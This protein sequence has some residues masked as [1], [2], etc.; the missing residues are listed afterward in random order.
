M[1]AE[2]ER[3]ITEALL[4][5]CRG[6]DR[7]DPDALLAAFHPGAELRDYGPEPMTVEAFTEYALPALQR[8]FTATQHRISNTAIDLDDEGA[9]ALVE[10]YVL[11]F[12]A[13]GDDDTGDDGP[14]KLHTFNGRYIDRFERRDDRWLIARRTLR[15]DWTRVETIDEPMTGAWIASGRAGSSD[16][17]SDPELQ[18]DR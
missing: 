10:T 16:P 2:V 5:Y 11:A 14:A 8:R 3:E 6:I 15:V 13:T 18:G 9:G 7:L 1:E 17:L 12:H 4:S